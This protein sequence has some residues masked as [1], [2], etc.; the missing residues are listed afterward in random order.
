M[1]SSLVRLSHVIET[2]TI[3]KGTRE[4][5]SGVICLDAFGLRGR[6]RAEDHLPNLLVDIQAIADGQSQC[7]PQFRNQRLYT[8]LTAA[9]MRRQLISQKSYTDEELPTVETIGC[10]MNELNYYPKTVAKSRPLKKSLKQM[11]SSIN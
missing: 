9:E 8:R 3:R 4:L 2:R 11:R 10:R 6:K 1:E 7:D 5:E